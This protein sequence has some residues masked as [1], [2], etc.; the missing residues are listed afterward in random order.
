MAKVN[1]TPAS[2]ESERSIA[3]NQAAA[4]QK[5]AEEANVADQQAMLKAAASEQAAQTSQAQE[6]S[7]EKQEQQLQQEELAA[8][9]RAQ[10]GDAK[11]KQVEQLAAAKKSQKEAAREAAKFQREEQQ[12]EQRAQESQARSQKEV[13]RARVTEMLYPIVLF[14]ILAILVNSLCIASSRINNKLAGRLQEPLLKDV[15]R[16]KRE[17]SE[18]FVAAEAALAVALKQAEQALAPAAWA[19]ASLESTKA[20][21][22]KEKTDAWQTAKQ[23]SL[24]KE[25]IKA[26]EE[27]AAAKSAEKAVAEK[28]GQEAAAPKA[29]KQN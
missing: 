2:T 15:D 26:A 28:A 10:E 21:A 13:L 8:E 3:L 20:N 22:E 23:L 25:R 19:E 1:E 24:T 12:A 7:V 18:F 17:Q 29:A 11:A 9:K 5:R 6:A 4:A 27:A 16:R 14:V